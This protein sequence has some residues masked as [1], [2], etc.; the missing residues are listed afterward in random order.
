MNGK[1]SDP[2]E[3]LLG[4]HRLVE[5]WNRD[6][7]GVI[8]HQFGPAPIGYMTFDQAGRFS[9]HIMRTPAV[10]P[11]QEG[12]DKPRPEEALQLLQSYYSAFGSYDVDPAESVIVFRSEGATRPDLVGTEG[13]FPFR[14]AQG[15]L[16]IG[17]NKTWHRVWERI[18]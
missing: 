8:I 6:A 3:P 18:S 13:R 9:V 1:R 7:E 17:D 2:R 5:H 15:N 10:P 12:P 14:V 16:L 4:T 11:F